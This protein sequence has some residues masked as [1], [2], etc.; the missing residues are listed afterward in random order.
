VATRVAGST[1][2][3]HR[4]TSVI[5]AFVGSHLQGGLLLER[6]PSD[7]AEILAGTVSELSSSS[8]RAC[9]IELSCAGD[10]RGEW[11][12]TLLA[13]LAMNLIDNALRHGK[14]GQPVRVRAIAE[15]RSVRLEVQSEGEIPPE[16]QAALFQ[17]LSQREDEPTVR[18]SGGLG[19]F[20]VQAIAR[21]HG[22]SVSVSSSAERGTLFTVILPR[23]LDRPPRR[24]RRVLRSWSVRRSANPFPA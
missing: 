5:A 9:A 17:M 23:Q 12:R 11:D 8:E 1:L 4:L 22:G 14:E 24:R 6:S 20:V 19:L 3:I 15:Q 21:A 16:R 2:R 10:C 18:F 13:Q 7:L